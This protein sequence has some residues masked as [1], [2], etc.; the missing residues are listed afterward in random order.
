MM[1]PYEG[2]ND[3]TLPTLLNRSVELYSE[4]KVL[5]KVAQE[6]MT[7]TELYENIMTMIKLLKENGITKGDKVALLSENM[8]NW[9]VAY[10][11]TTYFGAVIVPIL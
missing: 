6:P 4:K 3:F 5:S 2:M 1:Y 9:A 8:P 10:F 11:S 7:Y